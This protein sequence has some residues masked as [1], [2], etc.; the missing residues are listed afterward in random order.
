MW[1]CAVKV[2]E[3]FGDMLDAFNKL[4]ADDEGFILGLGWGADN[5]TLANMIAPLFGTGSGSNYTGYSNPEFD[6]LIAEG[7]QAADTATAV[8]KWQ[9]AREGPLPGLRRARHPVAQ[10]RRWLLHQRRER[11]DQPGWVHQHHG[12]LGQVGWLIAA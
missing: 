7:N 9:A 8:S 12:H 2:F 1:T 6:K 11:P 5:P 3:T 4:G 10:Q